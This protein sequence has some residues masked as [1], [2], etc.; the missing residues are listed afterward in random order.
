MGR[1]FYFWAMICLIS[2]AKSLDFETDSY[3]GRTTQA[4]FLNQAEKLNAS[5]KRLSRKKLQ[6]LQ[7]ISSNLASLNFQRNQDWVTEE[8]ML[9]Q[10]VLAFNGD[11]Y[12]GLKA[13][14]WTEEDMNFASNS[15]RIL[16]GLYGILRPTDL[17]KPYRLEMGT[18]IKV[19]RKKNLYDF[20]KKDLSEYFQSIDQSEL[21]LNLA[22]DEYFKAV[23]VAKPLQRIIK[24][25]FKDQNNN[26]DYKVMSFHAKKARGMMVNYII[27]NRITEVQDLVK[28]N[29]E[30]YY[31]HTN[32]SDK[33]HLVFL[34]DKIS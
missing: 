3:I 25:S 31:F 10:A 21:I 6:D 34:R 26:G 18:N 32:Q 11:V 2:P 29:E 1:F 12:T 9:K 30:N 19:G 16:S 20:W 24:F 33:N 17:I 8:K 5:L 7:S 4:D 22:S 14:S 15:L 13:N 28:F 27:K 23:A